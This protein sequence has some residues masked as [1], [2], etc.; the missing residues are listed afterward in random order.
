MT[1]GNNFVAGIPHVA[2]PAGGVNTG[3]RSFAGQGHD[4]YETT[5]AA[6]AGTQARGAASISASRMNSFG[7]SSLAGRSVTGR[8]TVFSGTT[9]GGF[10]R[11][12]TSGV[13]TGVGP[14]FGSGFGTFP[15]FRRP[16][17][18][19]GFG[20]GFGPGFGFGF[21]PG[22]GLGWGSCWGWDPFCFDSFAAWP[23]YGYFGS[24]AYDP[25]AYPPSVGYDPNYDPNYQNY[26]PPP[27]PSSAP[28]LAP[29]NPN[30]D[31]SANAPGASDAASAPVVI[32]LKDGTSFSPSDYW[33]S[34]DQLHY[35]L[36]GTESTVDLDRVDLPRSNDE[37]KKNGVKFWLRSAPNA[38]PAPSG[39]APTPPPSG[40][41]LTQSPI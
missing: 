28:S 38:S 4:I 41:D 35:V 23:P 9:V 26:N 18:G 21:G 6:S 36:G 32:Y 37:N 1:A 24:P 27:G 22:F 20:F 8:T 15:W 19:S 33:I 29:A 11:F 40:P 31:T 12:G 30:W 7:G 2:A 5:T 39:A 34:E 16:F 25:Y 17:F 3:T 14:R 13:F 10:G